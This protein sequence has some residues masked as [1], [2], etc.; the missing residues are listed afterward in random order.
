MSVAAATTPRRRTGVK[1]KPG[2]LEF[3][4]L[5]LVS[6]G[7]VAFGL[8]MVYSAT[9]APAALG[10]SDPTTS[11]KRQG[12]YA[13]LGLVA[14]A[15]AA[16]FDFRRLRALAP[17][18]IAVSALLCMFVA[19]AAPAVNG[20]RRW[21]AVG[22][23]T[24]QPS[25][26]AKFSVAIWVSAYLARRKAP[27][28]LK[29]LAR[30]IGLVGGF[31]ALLIVVEPDLG[32][33]IALVLMLFGILLVSGVPLP[34]L[35][36][37][38]GIVS[39]AGLAMLYTHAYQRARFFAF[40]HPLNDVQ[41]AGYQIAQALIGIGSGGWFGRGLGQGIQKIHY[42]PEANTD[43]IF[44]VIGEELGLVGV[45]LVVLAYGTFAYAGFRV[46]LACKDPF[47]KRLAAGLTTLVCGQAV[48]N[49][50]AV[51][52]I[53]PLTGIP[54]PFISYGGTNLL[55]TLASVGVLLNIAVNGAK[56]QAAAAVP[57]RSRGNSGARRP[58]A[59]NRRRAAGAGR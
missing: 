56:G 6:L 3:Q 14:M 46:A 49:L 45:T 2:A 23:L 30:P 25:E 53:A 13:L 29:E 44:A 54:L 39:L 42:L 16:R 47:G 50:A 20:A 19:V 22:P 55:L 51:L 57:D 15:V 28:T 21:I 27:R 34:T 31:F 32:T 8:V 58:G 18:L 52:G 4:L 5:V 24:F 12:M 17:T 43:M 1:R 38:A 40:F 41:G 11:L 59:G 26:L 37:S 9:S 7:L 10:G 35:G 36:A 48:V 33:T